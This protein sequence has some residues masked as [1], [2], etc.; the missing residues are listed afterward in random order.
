MVKVKYI[1]PHDEVEIVDGQVEKL[2]KRGET[3]EV[4]DTLAHGKPGEPTDDDPDANI[5]ALG[6]LLDQE[7]SWE[8]AVSAKKPEKETAE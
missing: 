2:V 6:G 5:G 8:L 3:I 7:D 1:G 4:S